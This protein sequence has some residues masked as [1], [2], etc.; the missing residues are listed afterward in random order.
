[1]EL[2]N[3]SPL[4]HQGQE[5]KGWPFV[6]CLLPLALTRQLE[7]VEDGALSPAS[8]RQWENVLTAYIHELQEETRVVAFLCIFQLEA[9]G[10]WVP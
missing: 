6:Y 4:G 7:S 10:G 5:I 9:G 8:E 1:M 2:W 3:S